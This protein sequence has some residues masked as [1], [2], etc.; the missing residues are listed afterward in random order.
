MYKTNLGLVSSCY[1]CISPEEDM[2]EKVAGSI[3]DKCVCAQTMQHCCYFNLKG[4]FNTKSLRMKQILPQMESGQ[5]YT[6]IFGQKDL[7]KGEITEER[8]EEIKI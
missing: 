6:N 1:L 3:A 8:T 4:Q 2:Q 7:R 5:F